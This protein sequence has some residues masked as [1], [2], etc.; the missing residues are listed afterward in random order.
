MPK[1]IIQP[2]DRLHEMVA[3]ELG[4]FSS[5]GLDYE[6]DT[7]PHAQV[8]KLI[9]STG[10]LT[11]IRSGA[12]QSYEQGKG[13]KGAKSDI[14]CACH[15]TVNN[16]AANRLGTMYGKAYVVT[17]GG[18]MV[19]GDSSI[20]LPEELAGAD[21]AVGFQSG[22]HYSTIQAL[23]AFVQPD[24]IKLKYVG[25]PWQ[26]LDVVMDG[27]LQAASLWGLTYQV[28]EQLGLRKVADCTFMITFMF[29][30]TVDLAD[31][32][33][34]MRAMK[35]A[36]MELD[37]RPEPYKHYFQDMIPG[38]YR[39]KVDV[40]RFSQGERIVFLPYTEEAFRRTQSWIHDRKIFGSAPGNV[41]YA[42]VVASV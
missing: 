8:S 19:R 24:E 15:W 5:E 32:E 14:S 27:D 13:N 22:S 3:H 41:E 28:A 23:E 40:R 37:L 17:P 39:D 29:P 25:R 33:K 4:Y 31:V 38:R 26:R 30:A 16:A 11:E 42:S 20:R 10:A 6:I 18:V 2:H 36:Q 34:Y 12:Y 7:R 9:D 35:R 1:F 21:I